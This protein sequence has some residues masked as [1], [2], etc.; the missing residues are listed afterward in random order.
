MGNA[1]ASRPDLAQHWDDTY[2]RRGT[3]GVSWF[4]PE[5]TMS[6]DVISHLGIAHD[7]AIIDVG[8]GASLLV[9]SLIDQGFS[10]VS[11]LDV[12]KAALNVPR[13][14]IGAGIPVR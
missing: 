4:Q 10:D 7:A 5:T 12:S 9:D 3:T 1:S 11:V 6:I 13:E 8:G 14:R 2:E